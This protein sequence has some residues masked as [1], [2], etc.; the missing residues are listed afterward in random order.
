MSIR[1]P[2]CRVHTTISRES[3]SVSHHTTVDTSLK[4]LKI[5][6]RCLQET[7]AAFSTEL[8][9]LERIY[10]K[11]KNQHRAALFW[12]KVIEIRRLCSRISCLE[13]VEVIEELR[14]TFYDTQDPI[15]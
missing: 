13:V 12:R 15:S 3:L 5:V 14:Y 6:H 2:T 7:I 8:Q 11:G 9:L 4:D 10:Y 1:S